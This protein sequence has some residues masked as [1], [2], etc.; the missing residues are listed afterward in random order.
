MRKVIGTLLFASFLV[1]SCKNEQT[2]INEE[3]IDLVQAKSTHIN[4]RIPNGDSENLQL[5]DETGLKAGALEFVSV[6]NQGD[7]VYWQIDEASNIRTIE[8]IILINEDVEDVFKNG[9]IFNEDKTTC[10]AVISKN[11]DGT[12]K[13]DIQYITEDGILVRVDPTMKVKI[14]KPPKRE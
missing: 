12:V 5:S 7:T 6:I 4:M 9:L 11:I 14:I 10:Y 8:D 3:I 13:Y 2:I 1:G